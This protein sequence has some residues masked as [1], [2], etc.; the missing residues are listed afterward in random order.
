[1]AGDAPWYSRW[2]ARLVKDL[3]G[4]ILEIGVG[5]GENLPYYRHAGQVWAIEPNYTRAARA[6]R[7][8]AIA[9]VP[10]HIG[11]APA[12]A[13]PYHS[14]IFDHVVS[15]LVFCSVSDPVKALEEIERVIKPDGTLHMVEHVC[16]HNPLLA[17]M[18][19]TVTPYWRRIAHNCHLNR[20]TVHLLRQRGWRVHI[21]RRRAVF[22]RISATYRPQ[23]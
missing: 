17:T 12:E 21:H 9:T 6:H 16:P 15:S 23:L 5:A 10:V 18:L 20:H 11:Q 4:N 2:R 1:M 19:A 14:S 7:S 3:T 13:L 22:L 8:A